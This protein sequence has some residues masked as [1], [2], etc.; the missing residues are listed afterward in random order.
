MFVRGARADGLPRAP[1]VRHRNHRLRLAGPGTP[2][3]APC[4]PTR[5]AGAASSA[6]TPA[7]R[8]S[9]TPA[10]AHE[11]VDALERER[12]RV[13]GAKPIGTS[14]QPMSRSTQRHRCV[15]GT[16]RT[17]A[18]TSGSAPLSLRR[19]RRA[20]P[21]WAPSSAVPRRRR[22]AEMTWFH[23]DADAGDTAAPG[24]GAGGSP[25]RRA[26]FACRAESR[27][28]A[29]S[30]S[31]ARRPVVALAEVFGR[32]A[33]RFDRVIWISRGASIDSARGR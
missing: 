12:Q 3:R 33:E 4:V 5:A 11:I 19:K 14:L 2:K 30:S 16:A 26:R 8:W 6:P 18:T 9:W 21:S 24:R 15:R 28:S 29:T 10:S 17:R 32:G 22:V 25:G 23:V 31:G 27:G 7:S 13:R 20:W 1:L